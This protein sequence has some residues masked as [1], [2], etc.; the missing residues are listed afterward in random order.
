MIVL[1]AE[2]DESF[3]EVV[4]KIRQFQQDYPISVLFPNAAEATR[5]AAAAIQSKW[6]AYASGEP[7]PSGDKLKSPTGGYAASIKT[8]SDSLWSYRIFSKAA[9]A[10][11]LEEGTPELDMKQTHPYG[12]RGRVAKKKIKGGGFRYVPYIIIPFRWATPGAGAHMGAKNVIPDQIYRKVLMAREKGGAQRFKR[13]IVLDGRSASPNF[14]GEMEGRASYAWGDRLKGVGGA[15]EG[16][17]AM[18]GSYD[19]DA[20]GGLKKRTPYST[21]FTFRIISADSPAGSWVKPAT[22][23][24]RIAEQTAAAMKDEA[25]KIVAEG[26]AADLDNLGAT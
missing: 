18:D 5:G 10:R 16:L 2:V 14:W 1:Q 3:A 11:W 23:A 13:T 19:A 4:G 15:L 24:L 6:K 20:G 12:Q 22:K 25:N 21:Y 7:L 17:V 8:E 26:V 9:V